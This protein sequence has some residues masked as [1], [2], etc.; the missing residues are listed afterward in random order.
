MRAIVLGMA[1]LALTGC[2]T[3]KK[4]DAAG[5]VHALLL[6]IRDNDQAA[7]DAHVDRA[8]LKREIQAKLVAEGGKDQRFGGLAAAL[9]PSLAELAGE[10]LVQPQ[11]FRLVAERYGYTPRTKIPGPVAISSALKPLPD[12]RVCA[13]REKDGPCL[14]TFTKVE[15]TWKLTG[16]E[17]GLSELR[18]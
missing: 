1:A 2:A 8:A 11:V 18:I 7:F 4:L 5:D 16:F 9:A 10:T 13:T 6:S 17:G 3:G 14:L 15:G 12:G